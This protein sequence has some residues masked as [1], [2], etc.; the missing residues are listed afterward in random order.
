VAV[1]NRCIARRV[2]VWP[3]LAYRYVRVVRSDRRREARCADEETVRR[4]LRRSRQHDAVVRARGRRRTN[5][6]APRSIS[7]RRHREDA[8]ALDRLL[9]AVWDLKP[10]TRR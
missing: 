10:L 9:F 5:P 8:D 3:L 6:E 2:D 4:E 7:A 1:P